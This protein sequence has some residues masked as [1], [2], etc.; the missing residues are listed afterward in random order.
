MISPTDADVVF[1]AGSTQE[2]I[3][4][5]FADGHGMNPETVLEVR[6]R[7][8]ESLTDVIPIRTI[9]D[10]PHKPVRRERQVHQVGHQVIE[11]SQGRARVTV[12]G[13]R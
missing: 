1:V 8:T 12:S 9:P 11:K 2:D 13:D 4:D 6:I 10:G 7:K 5:D 3:S